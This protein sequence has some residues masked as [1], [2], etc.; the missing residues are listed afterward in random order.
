MIM[1]IGR[2]LLFILTLASFPGSVFAY[3]DPGSGMMMLQG[4]I[5]LIGAVIVF[6]RNPLAA[7][8]RFIAKIRKK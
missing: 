3:V 6:F 4:L 5:A 7:I 8:K 2:K 1:E